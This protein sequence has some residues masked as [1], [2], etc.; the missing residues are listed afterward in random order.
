MAD[1]MDTTSGDSRE[2]V[3]CARGGVSGT[4]RCTSTECRAQGGAGVQVEHGAIHLLPDGDS[5]T[6]SPRYGL[7]GDMAVDWETHQQLRGRSASDASQ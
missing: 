2:K 6:R 5:A 7:P 1:E 3:R 4:A